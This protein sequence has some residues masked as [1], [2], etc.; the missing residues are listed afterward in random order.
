MANA[1]VDMAKL[2]KAE[3]DYSPGMGETRCRNC[4]HFLPPNSCEVVAGSI[5]PA[6]W[7]RRFLPWGRG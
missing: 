1:L 5:D 4:E 2:T 7:C 6:Y 3:V